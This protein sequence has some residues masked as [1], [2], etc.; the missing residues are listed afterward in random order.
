MSKQAIWSIVLAVFFIGASVGLH[1][2]LK[3]AVSYD[4][5]LRLKSGRDG[6]YIVTFEIFTRRPFLG[7]QIVAAPVLSVMEGS[8]GSCTIEDGESSITCTAVVKKVNGVPKAEGTVTLKSAD[9]E[10]VLECSSAGS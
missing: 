10:V 2:L 5:T 9:G 6:E 8:P 3:S 7:E 4:A 1:F